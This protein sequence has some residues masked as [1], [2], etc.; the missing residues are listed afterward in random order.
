MTSIKQIQT[1]ESRLRILSILPAFKKSSSLIG[2]ERQ[3]DNTWK[4]IISL[5]GQQHEKI[6]F[7][8]LLMNFIPINIQEARVVEKS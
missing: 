5:V 7:D 6:F 2:L 8:E 1:I 4:T 3:I